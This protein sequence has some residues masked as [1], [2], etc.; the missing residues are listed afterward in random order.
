MKLHSPKSEALESKAL[1]GAYVTYGEVQ[2]GHGRDKILLELEY[3]KGDETTC[4]VKIQFSKDRDFTTAFEQ[5]INTNSS[6]VQTVNSMVYQLTG[7]QNVIIPVESYG[8]YWRVQAKATGGTP[9]GTLD[10]GFRMDVINK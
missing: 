9:T 8:Y 4:E 2:A 5:V 3:T 6:G 10:A 1:T 7:T